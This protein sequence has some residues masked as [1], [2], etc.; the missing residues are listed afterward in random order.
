MVKVFRRIYKVRKEKEV[1]IVA[2]DR[3]A[4]AIDGA[5]ISDEM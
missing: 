5:F 3:R 4:S 2:G 1:I